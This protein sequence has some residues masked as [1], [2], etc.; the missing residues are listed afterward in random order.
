MHRPLL[1]VVGVTAVAIIA[2]SACVS[3]STP[4]NTENIC[5]IFDEKRSWYRSAARSERKWGIPIS[6]MMAV[7]YKESSFRATVRPPREKILGFIPGKRKSSSLG[8]S[9]AKEETWNDYIQA[10][11]N[12]TASRTNFADS[13]DFVG[14]YLNRAVRHLGVAPSNTEALYASYHV[15]LSGYQSGAWRD[16]STIR[17]SIATFQR[18]VQRYERQIRTCTVRNRGLFR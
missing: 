11:K 3:T 2:L 10:T 18:Q 7:I 4:S 13:I 9:Q 6:I 14:W 12:R 16:S 8:Y 17:N 5:Q 1:G 15:G